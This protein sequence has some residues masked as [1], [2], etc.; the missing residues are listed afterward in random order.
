MRSISVALDRISVYRL[1]QPNNLGGGGAELEAITR[2]LLQ[3]FAAFFRTRLG[4]A[5]RWIAANPAPPLRWVTVPPRAA[6]PYPID[7]P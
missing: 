3:I 6:H 4:F 1:R 5:K 7:Q 2:V